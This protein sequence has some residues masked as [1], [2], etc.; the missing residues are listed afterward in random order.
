MSDES[1]KEREAEAL[2]PV[3]VEKRRFWEIGGE[4]NWVLTV[5][6]IAA[7]VL[8]HWFERREAMACLDS[9]ACEYVADEDGDPEIKVKIRVE[10]PVKEPA[11]RA[12]AAD[13]EH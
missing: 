1:K 13:D 4:L 11:L 12:E 6:V 8:Y 10:A 5:L 9:G 3:Y 7:F 2:V